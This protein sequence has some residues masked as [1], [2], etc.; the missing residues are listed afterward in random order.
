MGQY[1]SNSKYF[2]NQKFVIVLLIILPVVSF[3]LGTRYQN[4]FLLPVPDNLSSTKDELDL[5]IQNKGKA[6]K[7]YKLDY[8]NQDLNVSSPLFEGRQLNVKEWLYKGDTIKEYSIEIPRQDTNSSSIEIKIWDFRNVAFQHQATF[9]NIGNAVPLSSINEAQTLKYAAPT[10]ITWNRSYGEL[11]SRNDTTSIHT[12]YIQ[13]IGD[14]VTGLP[15]KDWQYY[16]NS[17]TKELEPIADKIS[18]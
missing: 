1:K 6:A 10:K 17:S 3:Y 14:Q 16:V 4:K 18:F 2:I 5:C 12:I 15:N 7:S 9:D 8:P 13:I 11:S